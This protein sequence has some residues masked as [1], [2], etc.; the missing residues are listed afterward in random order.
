MDGTPIRSVQPAFRASEALGQRP[1]RHAAYPVARGVA[2]VEVGAL[3]A[4][5]TR[6]KQVAVPAG[7]AYDFTLLVDRLP[8]G[9]VTRVRTADV[10][11]L[12][13][14]VHRMAASTSW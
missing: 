4:D 1:P 7:E 12:A 5:M 2:R 8:D 14:I 9:S 11:D 10:D 13:D 6:N 3:P